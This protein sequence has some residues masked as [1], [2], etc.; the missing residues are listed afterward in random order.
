MNTMI[1]LKIYK[2]G[3]I[4]KEEHELTNGSS[5]SLGSKQAIAF[6]QISN[7][8]SCD[9]IQMQNTEAGRAEGAILLENIIA[10][11]HKNILQLQVKEER[12]TAHLAIL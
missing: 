3:T 6:F 4:T 5:Y 7:D 1:E 8:G 10:K 12:L 9:V 2:N 11:L